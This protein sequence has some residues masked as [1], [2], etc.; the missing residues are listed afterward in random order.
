M[1]LYHFY[2]LKP[3]LHKPEFLRFM[4]N[5]IPISGNEKTILVTFFVVVERSL[6]HSIHSQRQVHQLDSV[7]I[8]KGT[9][10]ELMKIKR[11]KT[12]P[13]A[14]LSSCKPFD[15]AVKFTSW[16]LRALHVEFKDTLEPLLSPSN[17]IPS[18]TSL[19]VLIMP[20]ELLPLLPLCLLLR[21]LNNLLLSSTL[22]HKVDLP[23]CSYTKFVIHQVLED[24]KAEEENIFALLKSIW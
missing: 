13:L 19:S 4:Q 12:Y 5:L 9:L 20:I 21:N 22:S 3:V 17:N 23:L 10:I 24:V 7:A 18:N 15:D 2:F 8:C 16:W 14:L 11:F 6:R 1:F